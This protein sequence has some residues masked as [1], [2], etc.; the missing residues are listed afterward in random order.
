MCPSASELHARKQ[1]IDNVLKVF[2]REVFISSL[3]AP[4][5]QT[6]VK[7]LSL[8]FKNDKGVIC[9]ALIGATK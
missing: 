9:S 4:R 2:S 6:G 1:S 8:L 3:K 5:T 7:L